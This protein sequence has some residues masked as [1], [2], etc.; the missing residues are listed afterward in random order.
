MAIN[1]KQVIENLSKIEVAGDQNGI[2]DGF[3]VLV[4]QLPAKFWNSF[5]ERLTGKAPDDLLE[6]V[7][8][9]LVNAAHEC[10][11]HTGYGIIT[12]KEWDAV[13]KPMVKNIPEDI[14]HGAYAVLAA[15]GWANAEIIE[16][17]PGE[18]MVVRAYDYYEAEVVRYGA[19]GKKSGYM[20]RG[21]CAAF[22]DL[23]Y[24]GTYDPIG[25]KSLRT[26]TCKQ[27]KGLECGDDYAE[28]VVTKA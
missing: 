6:S 25:K 22:M 21:I 20:L 2:I 12:S 4:N 15:F 10:G 1:R 11:Y 28:F 3:N 13:V 14:L 5:S 27:V 7:E 17:I 23:A 24:G 8:G 19:S 18:K 26:F 16:L 9:L